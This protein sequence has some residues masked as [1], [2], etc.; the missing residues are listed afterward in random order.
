MYQTI[1]LDGMTYTFRPT[2]GGVSF[3]GITVPTEHAELLANALSQPPYDLESALCVWEYIFHH[4]SEKPWDDYLDNHGIGAMRMVA[5]EAGHIVH[6][7]WKL[8]EDQGWELVGACYD[9]EFLPEVIKRL[10]WDAL[11]SGNQHGGPRYQ[12]DIARLAGEMLARFP[13][14]WIYNN[15]VETWKREARA[16]AERFWGYSAMIDEHP[17]AV[18][19]AIQEGEEPRDFVER[20]GQKHG[21]TP[22]AH[23]G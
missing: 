16:W 2:E 7:V 3:N 20:F 1:E 23:R 11:I 9:W 19:Q 18:E 17:E 13:D 8:L 15:P 21:L 4:H 10:D 5:A 14:W 12:P 6:R 22:R